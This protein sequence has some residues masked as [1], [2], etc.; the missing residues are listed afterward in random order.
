M[1][2]ARTT[3]SQ[4][5]TLLANRVES[6]P[7]WTAPESILAINEALRVWSMLTGMWRSR[8]NLVTLANDPWHPL[9]GNMTFRVRIMYNNGPLLKASL[10]GMD[11]LHPYWR[12]DTTLSGGD[13]P[14]SPQYWMPAGLQLIAIWPAD[15]VGGNTLTVDGVVDTPVL[16]LP[17][18]FIDIGDEELST[19]LGYAEHY[20]SFKEGGARFQATLPLYQAFIKAA[21]LKN[22]RLSHSDFFRHIEKLDYTR[23]ALPV[24]SPE[25]SDQPAAGGTPA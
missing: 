11:C 22:D 24:V 1:A 21:T 15:A 17:G 6:V 23:M 7:Y 20:L 14:T 25:R 12:T 3:L 4:M 8:V 13:V 5:Q 9:T 2:Y 19:L 16:A 10:F 18:D